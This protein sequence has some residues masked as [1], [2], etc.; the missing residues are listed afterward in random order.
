MKKHATHLPKR[1]GVG[2]LVSVSFGD[3]VS[4]QVTTV[5][6]EERPRARA[7][8][9]A[10]SGVASRR[11]GARPLERQAARARP[12]LCPR[13]SCCF[14]APAISLAPNGA[15]RHPFKPNQ[16][17]LV[18]DSTILQIHQIKVKPTSKSCVGNNRT[19]ISY[20]YRRRSCCW[21][22]TRRLGASYHSSNIFCFICILRSTL[23]LDQIYFLERRT[24]FFQMDVIYFST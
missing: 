19:K 9:R 7:Q 22:P 21:R 17:W 15:Q 16:G 1:C 20:S 12:P 23:D 5:N 14:V 8:R 3:H 10:P 24:Y 13:R 2:V 11:Q 4:R 6:R 18:L